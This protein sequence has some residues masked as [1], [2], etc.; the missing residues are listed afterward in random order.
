M[1]RGRSPAEALTHFG[2]SSRDEIGN[3]KRPCGQF[4]RRWVT[5]TAPDSD[6]TTARTRN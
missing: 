6:M 4:R 3:Y 1:N 2:L 5:L